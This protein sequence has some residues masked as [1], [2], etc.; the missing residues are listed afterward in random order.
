MASKAVSRRSFLRGVGLGGVAVRVGLPPLVAMFNSSGTAYAAKT[1]TAQIKQGR[2][3][4]GH[5]TWFTS[6]APYENPR[7]VV[8]VMMEIDP[9][10][11]ATG[12]GTCA[13]V[14]HQ[15][16]LALQKRE[17]QLKPDNPEI[18]ARR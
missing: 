4:V 8:V 14:A 3:I 2:K 7:Y 15:V 11:N 6:F 17:Q 12:G 13:P 5:T 9:G 1:G 18:L 10:Y 16:Y